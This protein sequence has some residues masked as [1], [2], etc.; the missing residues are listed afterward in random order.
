[1]VTTWGVTTWGWAH[2]ARLRA[3]GLGIVTACTLTA[4]A[5]VAHGPS[6]PP[7]PVGTLGMLGLPT[8]LGEFPAAAQDQVLQEISRTD[9]VPLRELRVVAVEAQDWS[10]SCLGLGGPAEICLAV[11][12]PGWRVT[13]ESDRHTWVYRLNADGTTL[14]RE[15]T[16]LTA[17]DTPATF[18][19]LPALKDHIA[20]SYGVA[21]T[22]LTL[23]A[24]EART[25]DGCYGLPVPPGTGCT[26]IAIPGARVIA[27]G[28]GS[29]WV[30]HTDQQGQTFRLNP[31][32]SQV[33]NATLAPQLLPP[34]EIP[35]LANPLPETV[36][37]VIMQNPVTGEDYQVSL[38]RDRSLAGY[39]RSRTGDHW[40][41]VDLGSV[42]YRDWFALQRQ[43]TAT[44][45]EGFHRLR[46][47]APPTADS[48]MVYTLVLGNGIAAVQYDGAVVDQL[49]PDLQALIALWHPLWEN[50]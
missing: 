22:D 11:I 43:L 14:R 46:Y 21:V 16:T 27:A 44:Q 36:L 8:D 17:G 40:A 50:R 29:V 45:L 28:A 33:S 15:S 3:V 12:T 32:A 30:Y 42:S 37:S 25:W 26:R 38:Y 48:A 2:G 7:V 19:F 10:D 13:V 41:A 6:S 31:V 23:V 35:P 1:M 9:Q 47:P 49:P 4:S 5:G 39:G 18:D 34:G 24:A 20:R